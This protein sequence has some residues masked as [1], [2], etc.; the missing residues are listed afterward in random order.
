M[1]SDPCGWSRQGLSLSL[2][3]SLSTMLTT[4]Q[5]GNNAQCTCAQARVRDN[6]LFP[7]PS[8]LF[9]LSPFFLPPSF[10]SPPLL[11]F[12]LP[13]TFFLLLSPFF[14]SPPFFLPLLFPPPPLFLSP[15]FSHF[16]LPFSPRPH[17]LCVG[18]IVVFNTRLRARSF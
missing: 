10:F 8:S 18:A 4:G 15:F 14:F 11:H 7:L 17:P 3:L 12:S 1:A 6:T 2:S 13:P 9:F 16:L 5:E